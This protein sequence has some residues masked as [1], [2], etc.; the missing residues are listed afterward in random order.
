MKMKQNNLTVSKLT[1]VDNTIEKR[2]CT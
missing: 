1:F 2:K